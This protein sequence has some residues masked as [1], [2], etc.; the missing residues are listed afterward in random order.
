MK[1]AAL[2]LGQEVF[3][4]LKRPPYA[5]I[6]RCLE[7]TEP[8]LLKTKFEGWH[9]VIAVDFTRTAESVQKTGA[10][11]IKWMSS[12][13]VKVDLAALFMPRQPPMQLD[14]AMALIEEW[15]EDLEVSEAF[16]LEGKRFTKLPEDEVG[17]FFSED[18][19]VFLC[20]YW[21]PLDES[22][23]EENE[24]PEDDFQCIVFFWQGRDASNMGWLT[25]TFTLQKKF[26]LLFGDKLEV[27]KC[28]QQQENPKFL[29]HFKR[30]FLIHNGKRPSAY[31][32]TE[33]ASNACELSL[34]HLRSNNSPLTLR[35]IQ[36][37]V[38]SGLLNSGFC[39]IL[40]VPCDEP[41]IFVWIGS[42][43]KQDEADI[44]E[45]IAVTMFD[46]RYRVS[47]I[48]EHEEGDQFWQ[49]IGD[50]K[51]YEDDC[52]FMQYTRLFRCSNDKGYFSVSEKCAD[53]CQ[54]DLSDDDIM[55]LDNGTQTF[56]WVGA[57]C[58]D[59]EIKLAYKSAQV[60]VQNMRIKQPDR[61]RQLMLTFKG[62][63][64]KKFTKCFHGWGKHKTI[65]DPRANVKLIMDD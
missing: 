38:D 35:C 34:Y 12:Q 43:A 21:V 13:E 63:E 30:K 29:A 17:H 24:N 10:N 6:H 37:P 42:K 1:A 58:T 45:Q 27:V 9:D 52:S 5:L 3:S 2:K 26:K 57:R 25:F 16:V 33:D 4:L 55:I 22:D 50:K 53:F 59:V 20:R 61:P 18:C 54:D 62:K 65:H 14:E 64:S 11:L 40:K 32:I 49:A 31:K 41:V 36:V 47:I 44:A 56:I 46:E 19:Y 51:E 28:L 23:D 48:N 7:G 15:N 8:Q 60:Y 39:Y